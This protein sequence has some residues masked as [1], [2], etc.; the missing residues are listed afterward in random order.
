MII[1]MASE[2]GRLTC[3]VSTV[4]PQRSSNDR[5]VGNRP[6][7]DLQHLHL[8]EEAKRF[9]H[10]IAEPT[11]A[12]REHIRPQEKCYLRGGDDGSICQLVLLQP[13]L[14]HREEVT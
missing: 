8:L 9:V 3:N 7:F 10:V 1:K 4:A 13:S 2:A 11:R 5:L 14:F 12:S 6:K